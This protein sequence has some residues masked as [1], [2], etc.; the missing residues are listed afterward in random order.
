MR[1]TVICVGDIQLKI[2]DDGDGI[3][4]SL[5]TNRGGGGGRVQKMKEL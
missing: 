1:S 5:N 2:D 3:W 4:N